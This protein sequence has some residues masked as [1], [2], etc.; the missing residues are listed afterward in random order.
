MRLRT[1][2]IPLSRALILMSSI[3]LV[4][5]ASSS[6]IPPAAIKSDAQSGFI[7][8]YE[9]FVIVKTIQGDSLGELAARYLGDPS[10][11]WLIAAFNDIDT[12]LPGQEIVI[13]LKPV[14]LGGL[15]MDGFQKVPILLY[16]DFSKTR[17]SKMKVLESSFE[18][19]MRFLKE[20]DYHVITLDQFLNFMEYKEQIPEKSVVITI[21]DG[22]KSL[23]TIAYPI[24]KKYNYPATLF[25]YTDF[26]GGNKALTWNQIRE[27]AEYGFDIQCHTK[28]HRY[29]TKI[30]EG[31]TFK[32]FFESVEKELTYPKK[33]L[34]KKIDRDCNC[35][36]YPYGK[37]SSL[38]AAMLKKYG[39]RAAFTVTRG[40]N[41]FY[42]HNYNI[43]RSAIYGQ[44]DLEKFKKNLDVFQPITAE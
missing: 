32:Q 28:T 38:V 14:Q 43:N 36:A 29:L 13:P 30:K 9:D 26:I 35:L 5:C 1:K 23:Y 11:A 42:L 37:T 8:E 4:A 18:A 21:D 41:P 3:L 20:N 2:T 25:V 33:L 22:W 24:L 19:Q 16:H 31:E 7:H 10:K 40:G 34:K 6:V 44:Y 12:L 15:N 17:S 27:L 39:Y